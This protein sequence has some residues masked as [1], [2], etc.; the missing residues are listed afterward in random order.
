M[1]Q[2]LAH[3]A[4]V[5]KDYNEAIKYYTE[6]LDFVLIEDTVLTPEKRWVMVQP[7]GN[8]NGCM[9]LLAKA[10]TPD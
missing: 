9:L 8:E 2:R 6:L 3:I 7:K 10:A 1:N 4:I 5:V